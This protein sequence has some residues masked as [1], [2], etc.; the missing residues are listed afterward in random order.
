LY[1]ERS[2]RLKYVSINEP[3]MKSKWHLAL[4]AAMAVV[5][6]G[7][8]TN[9]YTQRSQLVMTSPSFDSKLGAAAYHNILDDPATDIS[10][11]PADIVPVQRVATRIIDA[12][13]RSKYAAIAR[14][15]EWDVAVI[16]EDGT[17]NAVA[18]PGGKFLVYTGLFPIAKNEAGLAAVLGHEIVH[19][20]A[21]HGAEQLTH[22]AFR[23]VTRRD[24][25]PFT[26]V[27]E[28]EADYIGLLLTAEAGYDPHE[29]VNMWVRMKEECGDTLPPDYLSS[30]PSY[31]A[32]IAQLEIHMPEARALY[33][34][35]RV[36]P[37]AELPR[38]LK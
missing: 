4:A 7:C 16:D 6:F 25:L 8:S 34:R 38:I 36:A 35:S 9:P 28:S 27:Q 33:E 32:R 5:A 1:A 3:T 24:R 30:H 15:F 11:N 21:R 18:F 37:E 10:R 19:A 13:K 14:S 20:L 23:I 17:R 31:D 2:F 12:A 22:D 29:A 26:R